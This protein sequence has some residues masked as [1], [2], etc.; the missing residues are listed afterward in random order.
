M[1]LLY[2]PSAR[3]DIRLHMTV[4]NLYLPTESSLLSFFPLSLDSRIQ[5]YQFYLSY[6]DECNTVVQLL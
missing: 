2:S 4:I 1:A 3:A 5:V 6:P